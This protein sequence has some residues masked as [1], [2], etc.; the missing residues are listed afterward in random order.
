MQLGI[1]IFLR[2]LVPTFPILIQYGLWAFG[3]YDPE[4]PQITYTVMA[5]ALLLVTV[6]EYNSLEQII[7]FSILPSI[8]T[9]LLY[10]TALFV[11]H[12]QSRQYAYNNVLIAGFC[13]WLFFIVFNVVRVFI[14]WRHKN[15]T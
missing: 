10:L 3:L 6:T 13:L 4:F 2:V 7:Y 9:S 12:D 11:Q 1:W 14:D 8:V 5:F 15:R